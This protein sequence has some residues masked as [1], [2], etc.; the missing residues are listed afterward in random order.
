MKLIL[1]VVCQPSRIVFILERLDR[2]FTEIL[3]GKDFL[4]QSAQLPA[5]TQDHHNSDGGTQE[6]YVGSAASPISLPPHR[7]RKGAFS[8][9][10]SPAE[11]STPTPVPLKR[12]LF[13]TMKILCI[14][15]GA[16]RTKFMYRHGSQSLL[17][18][19]ADSKALWQ[20]PQNH[21][22]LN[23]RGD[24]SL[25]LRLA[26][27]LLN[28][29]LPVGLHE[30]D[31]V[32]FSVPGTVEIPEDGEEATTVRN[33]PNFSQEFRGFDFKLAFGP[34]FPQAKLHAV[35]DNLAAAFG[36]AWKFPAMACG[37]VLVLGTAPAVA[38]FFRSSKKTKNIELA[39]WQSWA[40]F[41]K[42]NLSDPYGYCGGLKIR[43]DG[44]TIEL[45]DK[46]AYKIPHPKAR[47]R[48]ALDAA[49]WQ[50]LRGTLPDFPAELQGNLSESEAEEI[51][52]AR[53]Q[54]AVDALAL[55]F[56]Q[57]YGRPEI[58]VILGGHGLRC[59]KKIQCAKYNDPDIGQTATI[60][61]PVMVPESDDDQQRMHLGGLAQVAAHKRA[62]VFAPGPDPLAR[63]WTRGGE[64][65]LW[66]RR[67][68]IL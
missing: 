23:P 24:D 9:N 34:L 45:K 30:L 64:I 11:P 59:G 66:V 67:N 36:V 44:Q 63:G 53:A 57:V 21:K 19:P 15:I 56:H 1:A 49:T 26:A 48:F 38:T 62:H 2:A 42:I 28:S 17:L 12:K 39:I 60:T 40:W 52:V 29:S 14:D 18:P 61:V 46:K 25:R 51:W 4:N 50:R 6:D 54:S 3:N 55:R 22:L 20:P 8:N 65:Y 47:I 10:R 16:T 43:P 35:P 7:R 68:E 32:V 27:L 41:T 5:S 31:C 58:V 33:M 13:E 37:L